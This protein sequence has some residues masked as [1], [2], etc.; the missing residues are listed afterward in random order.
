MKKC[1]F[2]GAINSD[3][4]TKCGT[5]NNE[6]V[7]PKKQERTVY[8]RRKYPFWMFVALGLSMLI[9]GTYIAYVI[10][11]D[12]SMYAPFICSVLSAAIIMIVAYWASI[13]FRNKNADE[14]EN[15]LK[16]VTSGKTSG[17]TDMSN[18][19]ARREMLP[20]VS[21]M[22]KEKV[23][24]A[25][26]QYKAPDFNEEMTSKEAYDRLT[27]GGYAPGKASARCLLASLACK[28]TVILCAKDEKDLDGVKSAF[29]SLFGTEASHI[30][31]D[32]PLSTSNELYVTEI[33]NGCSPSEFLYEIVMAKAK[34]NAVCPIVVSMPEAENI[35]ELF[36]GMKSYMEMP[37][38]QNVITVKNAN[39]C[40]VNCSSDETI[41]LPKNVRILLSLTAEQAY[42]LPASFL[43]KCAFV[44]LRCEGS[45]NDALQK[46]SLSFARLSH[47]GSESVETHYLSETIWNKLDILEEYISKAI[48]FAIDNK[49]ANTMES[50]VS[51]CMSSGAG[52]IEALDAVLA[53]LVLPNALAQI[54]CLPEEGKISLSSQLD[55]HFGLDNLPLC[56]EILKKFSDA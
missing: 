18:P 17:S 45:F 53:T 19:K 47:L 14:Y 46:S 50:F 22:L 31:I 32:G 5:C 8:E 33:E 48:P 56:T 24:R 49:L 16:D 52:E 44:E 41:C 54:A 13:Y 9:L 1:K 42:R 21:N 29:D 28:R 26:A 7:V 10:S 35:A 23:G 11:T 36:D 43:A 27:V 4:A 6:F 39:H 2:C 20:S 3:D 25:M 12:D 34:E 37:S 30:Q 15:L 55:T 38:E 40:Y 51:I